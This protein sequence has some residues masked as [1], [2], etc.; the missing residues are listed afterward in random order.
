MCAAVIEAIDTKDT[1]N[2]ID[3]NRALIH[4]YVEVSFEDTGK[5]FSEEQ[6]QNIFKPFCSTKKNGTGLGLVITK[7]IIE[8][9]NGK[10]DIS[11]KMGIGT[12]VTITLPL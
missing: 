5:G 9:H 11:I 6:Q 4:R 3:K 10:I 12:V 2:Q 8:G 1:Q 7:S